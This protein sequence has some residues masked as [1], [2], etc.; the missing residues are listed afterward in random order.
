[1]AIMSSQSSATK[2]HFG[3]AGIG[4]GAYAAFFFVLYWLMQPNVTAN[5]GL[6]GYRPPPKTIVNM[7]MR[8]GNLQ[9]TRSASDAGRGRASACYRKAQRHGGAEERDKEAGGA[10]NP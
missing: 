6:A 3:A 4:L 10:D 2:S 5:S 8:R 1:M 9:L 7:Q